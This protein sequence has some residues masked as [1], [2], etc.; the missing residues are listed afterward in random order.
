MARVIV[1]DANVL[2][3]LLSSQDAHHGWAVDLFIDSVDDT[4]VISSLTLSE[5]MVHPARNGQIDVMLRN[6]TSLGIKVAPLDQ[7]D[8]INLA[9]VRAR[10]QLR[11]P[12]A[13]VLHTA[14]EH[15]ASLATLD[16]RLAQA[17]QSEGLNVI[18]L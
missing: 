5:A 8:S 11:M 9:Y 17:A 1:L 18:S 6:I 13:L 7:A 4:L 12:D 2:I 16:A 15:H 10:T 3:A 14:I